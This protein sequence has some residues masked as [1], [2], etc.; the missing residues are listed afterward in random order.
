MRTRAF[1]G[2]RGPKQG[3]LIP[4]GRKADTVVCVPILHLHQHLRARRLE[5]RCDAV[6]H[7]CHPH[8][9]LLS[10]VLLREVALKRRSRERKRVRRATSAVRP[11]CTIT[12]TST[13]AAVPTAPTATTAALPRLR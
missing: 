8:L 7:R 2:T 10:I 6:H 1:C 12:H 3:C 5:L 11:T 4:S 13:S 9:T